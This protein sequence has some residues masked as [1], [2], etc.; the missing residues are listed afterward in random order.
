MEIKKYTQFL[1]SNIHYFIILSILSGLFNSWYNGGWNISKNILVAITMFL[2]IFPVMINMKIEGLK[3]SLKKPSILFFSLFINFV[4]SPFVAWCLVN[5]FLT[6]HPD[7]Y[8]SIMILS[9]IP[10]SAMTAV[11]THLSGG[12]VETAMFLIPANLLFTALIA[13]PFILPYILGEAMS[14]G[15]FVFIKSISLVFFLP[16]ILG[17]FT[18]HLIIKKFGNDIYANVI[19][20]ELGALSSIGIL[21]L[22]FLVMS[23]E[24]TKILFRHPELILTIL[25]PVVLYYVLM[26]LIS[27]IYIK[28]IV[29]KT[30][31]DCRDAIVI[32]YASS[33]RH[34]NITLAVIFVTFSMED[35]A[36]MIIPII[37]GF[38]V[39]IPLLAFYSKHYGQNFVTGCR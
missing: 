4:I 29:N 36:M 6:D 5:Y 38:I 37:L 23:L 34:L 3:K 16:L 26:L 1:R 32:G 27:T 25:V 35:S 17:I 30:T 14:I 22:S 11:W 31:I 10:T 7:I 13:I 8:V 28:I 20:P 9:F 18:R 33:V 24:R 15:I 21:I 39:Q 19:K 12:S 2:V